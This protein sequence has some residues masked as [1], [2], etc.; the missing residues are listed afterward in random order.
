MRKLDLKISGG[1]IV[2]LLLFNAS[3]AVVTGYAQNG[4]QPKAKKSG[5]RNKNQAP[6]KGGS[7]LDD[8]FSPKNKPQAK[9]RVQTGGDN[10]AKSVREDIE[11]PLGESAPAANPAPANT[12]ATVLPSAAAT[13]AN[14][15]KKTGVTRLCFAV[16][17]AQMKTSDHAQAAEAV[18]NT[19]KSYLAGPTIEIVALTARLPSQAAEEAKQGGCDYVLYTS[20]IHKKGGGFLGKA[21]G[22][23]AR[24]S[25]WN[26]PG[27]GSTVGTI[28]RSAAISGVYT[29]ASLAASIK[30]KDEL[31]LGY[32]LD[33]VDGTKPSLVGTEKAKAKSD[34]ED[35]L[36]PLIEKAAESIVA[37]M[38]KR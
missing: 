22:D 26:I 24:S 25:V 15:P 35:V 9:T 13:S 14:A 18:S 29:A 23:A 16:P 34:G 12:P 28:A 2:L 30:A 17:R 7:E 19:F 1:I 6:P 11:D 33:A 37:A 10:K 8:G 36:T 5:D 38:T 21:L 27:G 4:T 20:L 32:K 3:G 31:T